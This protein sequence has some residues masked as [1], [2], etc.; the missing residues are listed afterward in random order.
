M[1]IHRKD[2]NQG[3][4]DLDKEGMVSDTKVSCH[5]VIKNNY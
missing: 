3:E 4:I 1:N 2:L 5:A